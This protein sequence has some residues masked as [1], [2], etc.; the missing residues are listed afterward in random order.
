MAKPY[1]LV[2][3]DAHGLAVPALQAGSF[4]ADQFRTE[5]EGVHAV[6]TAL[7]LD[8]GIDDAVLAAAREAVAGHYVEALPSEE[9]EF[10]LHVAAGQAARVLRDRAR[11]REALLTVVGRHRQRE[12]FD[13]GGTVRGLLSSAPCPVWYQPGEFREVHRVVVAVDFSETSRRALEWGKRLAQACEAH[14]AV[15]HA[16][17]PPEFAYPVPGPRYVVHDLVR[18]EEEELDRFLSDVEWP[19]GRLDTLFAVGEPAE[20]I[21]RLQDQADVLVV[22]TSGRSALGRAVLGSVAYSVIR[23]ARIAVLAVR[24]E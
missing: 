18:Q 4:L 19:E 22:G 3:L 8:I 23:S 13:F 9:G 6:D 10:Q 17:E 5:L 20:Q 11:E 7:A 2:G 24:P 12:V 1:I 16:F 14:L 21:L 15:A